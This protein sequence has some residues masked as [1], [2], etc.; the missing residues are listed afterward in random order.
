MT[1]QQLRKRTALTRLIDKLERCAEF[2][3]QVDISENSLGSKYHLFKDDVEIMTFNNLKEVSEY[4]DIHTSTASMY[5]NDPPQ[6]FID[7]GFNIEKW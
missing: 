3:K 2:T 5:Y 1:L 4:F 7:K 6:E